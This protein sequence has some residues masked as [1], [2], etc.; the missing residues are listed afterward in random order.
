MRHLVLTLLMFAAV[1]A[2]PSIADQPKGE[3]ETILQIEKDWVKAMIDGNG[4]WFRNNMVGDFKIVFPEGDIWTLDEFASA[5][6]SGKI[7]MKK[8]D[9]VE[10]DV[11]IVGK[12]AIV[13]GQGDV[14]GVFDGDA[15]SHT[16]KWTDVYVKIGDRWKCVA[17]HVSKVKE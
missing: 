15:F 5:W 8:C 10:L 9:N 6:T 7:D 12:T 14:T 1:P 11:R 4:K 16:E 3:K 17:C 13:V 2:L